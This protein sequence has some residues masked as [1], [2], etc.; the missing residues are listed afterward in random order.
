MR[1]NTPWTDEDSERLKA[2]VASGASVVRAA[3]VF[4]RTIASIRDQARKLG[5]P[6][7]SLNESRKKFAN[8]PSSSW[9]QY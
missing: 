4:N 5:A 9:R 2:L 7:P 6:F 3:A 1:K 8:S